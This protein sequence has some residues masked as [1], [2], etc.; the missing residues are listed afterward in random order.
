M[1][2]AL[3]AFAAFVTALLSGVFGMA[4]G[5]VLMGVYTALLPVPTAMVLHGGSQL[6]AN[7]SRAVILRNDVYWRGFRLY[8]VG[9]L[10]AFALLS[11]LRYVPD[12]LVVFL[13]LGLAPFLAPLMPA[14]LRDFERPPAALLT[15]FLVAAGQLISGAAGPLLDIAFVRSRLTRHEVVATKAVT[16]V[17]SHVLKLVYFV[18]ALEGQHITPALMGALVVATVMGTRIGTYVLERMSDASF[19][20]YTRALVYGIGG[21]YLCKAAWLMFA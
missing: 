8:V 12:P 6:V 10:S 19:R 11:A 15:G 20:L 7:G 5:M 4:G 1:L 2:I 18:P 13:G 14:S 16:Q 9:A 21:V 17:F 3:L